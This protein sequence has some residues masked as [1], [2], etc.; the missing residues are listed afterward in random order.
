MYLIHCLDTKSGASHDPL[1]EN[2][3]ESPLI[4]HVDK[5]DKVKRGLNSKF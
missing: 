1:A 3:L 5:R 2:P 4:L